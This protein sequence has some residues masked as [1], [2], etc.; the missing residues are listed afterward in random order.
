M[1]PNPNSVNFFL[2]CFRLSLSQSISL[3]YSSI[4]N[5]R[6]V[7]TSLRRPFPRRGFHKTREGKY[8]LTRFTL[9]LILKLCLI[10]AILPVTLIYSSNVQSLPLTVPRNAGKNCTSKKRHPRT[11]KLEEL[12]EL[13][14]WGMHLTQL[15]IS[16]NSSGL[17]S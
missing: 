7:A 4:I 6:S 11:H 15:A 14:N 9:S 2:D 8:S 17:L 3:K 5:S 13:F 1:Y 10:L 16:C 12:I